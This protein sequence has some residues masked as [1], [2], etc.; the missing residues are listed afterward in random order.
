MRKRD[1]KDNL[2]EE[3]KMVRLA[4]FAC[5]HAPLALRFCGGLAETRGCVQE[6]G[7]EYHCNMIIAHHCTIYSEPGKLEGTLTVYS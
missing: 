4:G 6:E 3:I 2:K 1:S 5:V 7:A